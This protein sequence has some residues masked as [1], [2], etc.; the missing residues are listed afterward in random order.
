M[1]ELFF[2]K[3]NFYP[4][5][6]QKTVF[7]VDFARL[8]EKGIENIFIDLDNTLIPY[9]I[10]E[11]DQKTLDLFEHIHQLGYQVFIVSNNRKDRVK[12]FADMVKSRYVYSAQKPFKSGFRKALKRVG[13][14]DPKTVCLIGDQF[15]TDVLGGKRMGF[16]VIVVDA[17]KRKNEKWYTKY[18]RHLEKKILQRLKR[19]DHEFY[20]RLNL[21]EKR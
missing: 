17:I 4:D 10:S 11:A 21:Q 19:T 8:K 12:L 14:P 2:K 3:K 20:N 15:M 1:V 13:N 9:D 18:N 5:D 6:Y 7:D 16:Y